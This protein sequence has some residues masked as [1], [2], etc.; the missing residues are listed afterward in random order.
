MK[1]NFIFVLFIS[2]IYF[3]NSCNLD[4]INE[5]IKIINQ[6]NE[7]VIIYYYSSIFNLRHTLTTIYP[8]ETKDI[9][10]SAGTEY[11]TEGKETKKNYG[12]KIFFKVPSS[13]DPQQTWVIM[14]T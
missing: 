10:I 14:D 5:E 6:T 12:S 3:I 7:I 11:Y 1:R 8:D 9:V 13:W 4:P 2:L